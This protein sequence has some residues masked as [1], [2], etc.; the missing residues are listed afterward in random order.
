MTEHERRVHDKS[1]KAYEQYRA[2][3]SAD[4][5][6]QSVTGLGQHYSAIQKKIMTKAFGTNNSQT[7]SPMMNNA[8]R[9]NLNELVHLNGGGAG[10][11]TNANSTPIKAGASQS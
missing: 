3:D 9:P 6:S 1:I 11:Y 8:K 2:D 4:G 5:G 10:Q 7:G